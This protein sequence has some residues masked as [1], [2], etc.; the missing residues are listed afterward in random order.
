MRRMSLGIWL[1]VAVL[2]MA[3]VASAQST[4]G[5]ISG[6]VVDTQEATVPGVTVS[7]ESANLQGIRT[8]VTSENGDYIFTL[9]PSGQYTITFE[10][11][12]FE[13]VQRVVTV[14]PTQTLPVDVTMGLAGVSETVEVVGRAADVLTQTAQVATNF[15]QELIAN[16]PTNRDINSTLL[17]APSVHSTGPGGN[18]SI[19]GSMSFE[20]LFMINGVSVNENIRGTGV[21]SLH[22]GRDPGDDDFDRRRLGRVRPLWRR[23]RERDHQVGREPVQRIVPRHVEQRRLADAGAEARWRPVRQRHQAR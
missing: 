2:A 9:L 10:L 17:L 1:V 3:S 15:P 18:Y 7:V 22:R 21:Q 14:A 4:T 20:N 5:T 12:G 6:R 8:A 16:L 11:S 13:R 23:R 19:A